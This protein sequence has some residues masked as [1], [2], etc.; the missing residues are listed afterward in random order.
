MREEESHYTF[1]VFTPTFNRGYTLPYVYRSLQAQ[2]L[3]DF[4]WLVVDDG[5][6]DDTSDLVSAWQTEAGFPIRYIYQENR[7]KH[8]AFNCG[9]REARGKLFF[10]IDSDDSCV[11]KTLERFNYHWASIPEEQKQE[12]STV[13][14]L[15]M[16]EDGSILGKYFP[17]DVLDIARLD[18]QIKYRSLAERCGVNQTALLRQ[19][20]FPEIEGER[21][22]SEG[23]V[24]NR[25]SQRYKTRFVNE[26]LVRKKWHTDGLS[27]SSVAI[28]ARNPK[29]ARLYYAEYSSL[30]V[31]TA[32][33]IKA[34]INYIRFS[35]H[36]GLGGRALAAGAS[37]TSLILMLLPL[38]Y[39]AYKLDQRRLTGV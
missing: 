39:L 15:C 34:L 36:A 27:A 6:T 26:M 29:G 20:P 18:I 1:T 3:R 17:A 37:R 25:L 7:G 12:Y 33:K 23:I 8:V 22:I 9:V 30:P 35:F 21:F 31:P 4:E 11:P 38:G 5:S 14:A 19:C 28:R 16:N 32:W 10:I 2:T 24:W 13:T